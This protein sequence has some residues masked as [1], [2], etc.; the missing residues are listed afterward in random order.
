MLSSYKCYFVLMTCVLV[1][2]CGQKTDPASGKSNP[3]QNISIR[4]NSSGIED[5]SK[6]E[7]RYASTNLNLKIGSV[8]NFSVVIRNSMP[9]DIPEGY[10]SVA[11]YWWD[12]VKSTTAA[13]PFPCPALPSNQDVVISVPV[14][15][16]DRLGTFIFVFDLLDKNGDTLRTRGFKPMN[17]GNV[18]ITR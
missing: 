15:P 4:S 6:I 18:V 9:H 11:T 10:L 13:P 1:T 16:W 5:P 3:G 17:Y 7:M 2:A 8:A 14:T 12:G